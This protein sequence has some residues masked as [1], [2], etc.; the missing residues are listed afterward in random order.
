MWMSCDKSGTCNTICVVSICH[1][2]VHVHYDTY[3]LLLSA[4]LVQGN[5]DSSQQFA[6]SKCDALMQLLTVPELTH[7]ATSF[8][9][10]LVMSV[11]L[12]L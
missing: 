3:C 1:L 9:H 12:L 11:F 7:G 2:C 6:S 5:R 4:A 10:L 8:P